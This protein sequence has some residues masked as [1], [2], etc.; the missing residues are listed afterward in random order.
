MDHDW[1]GYETNIGIPKIYKWNYRTEELDIVFSTD[2]VLS[3]NGTKG[4]P[5][6]QASIIGDWRE[7]IICRGK[8][9]TFLRV[10]TTT[11]ITHHRFYTFMHDYVYRLGIAWQNTAYNQ[12]PHTSFYI[13]DD[14][15]YI[16][17]PDYTY[18]KA[19]KK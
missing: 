1:Y 12:P 14:M 8:D 10:Y 6:L 13:G 16:P 9:S 5:C 15:E 11:D 2:N 18:I 4:N 3:N 17:M 19:N 7:E